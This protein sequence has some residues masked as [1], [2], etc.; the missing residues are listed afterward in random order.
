MKKI[1]QLLV[2]GL[3]MS[4]LYCKAQNSVLD[5]QSE[6]LIIDGDNSDWKDIPRYYNTDMGL[7]FDIR[8]DSTN[9]Y[10]VFRIPDVMLQMRLLH[11]GFHVSF[12]IKTKPKIITGITFPKLSRDVLNLNDGPPDISIVAEKFLLENA[13]ATLEGFVY[14]NGLTY[15]GY[16]DKKMVSFSINWN[17]LNEMI[18]EFQIP[19]RE[20]YGDNFSFLEIKKNVISLLAESEAFTKPTMPVEISN[21]GGMEGPPGGMGGP[22]G[23]M[24]VSPGGMGRPPGGGGEMSR[25]GNM[26]LSLKQLILKFILAEKE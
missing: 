15:S 5:W 1:A 2:F 3:I 24:G 20:F 22:P 18:Y 9:L 6:K 19:I 11:T 17:A 12:K 26:Q 10:I 25:S 4:C 8:N 16:Q 23:G 13:P 7:S 14:S 21:N